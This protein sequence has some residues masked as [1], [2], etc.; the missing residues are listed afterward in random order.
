ML[1]TWLRNWRPPKHAWI[2]LTLACVFWGW[3]GFK[4]IETWV[5]PIVT[6]FKILEINQEKSRTLI[7]GEMRKVRSC[8]FKSMIAVSGDR[9][10]SI[11]FQ[12]TAYNSTG[13]VSRPEGFY[14]WGWWAVIPR[15]SRL[16]LYTEHV[17]STGLVTTKLWE[18]VLD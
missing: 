4:S 2:G 11:E 8:E 1:I 6:D 16:A 14:N 7:A 10:V 5:W 12:E 17:C 9:I 15:V 13:L 3:Q 18:G